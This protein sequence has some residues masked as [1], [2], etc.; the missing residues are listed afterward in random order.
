MAHAA[1]EAAELAFDE[2][3]DAELAS[4][5]AST[6]GGEPAPAFAVSDAVLEQRTYFTPTIVRVIKPFSVLHTPRYNPAFETAETAG[7]QPIPQHAC[8]FPLLPMACCLKPPS[9]G[10]KFALPWLRHAHGDT[11]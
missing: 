5:R 6:F 3:A 8:L 9:Q 4:R 7:S 1:A 2:V 11:E 10:V